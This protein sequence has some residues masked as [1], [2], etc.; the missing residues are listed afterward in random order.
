MCSNRR[1]RSAGHPAPSAYRMISAARA[2]VDPAQPVCS[3]ESS[4]VCRRI[5]AD[6]ASMISLA[7][8]ACCRLPVMLNSRACV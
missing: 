4:S 3:P 6:Q 1:T 8:T 7:F 5:L 2:Q